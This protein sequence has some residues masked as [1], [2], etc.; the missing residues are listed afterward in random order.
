MGTLDEIKTIMSEVPK[1]GNV[2]RLSNR[3]FMRNT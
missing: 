2:Q 1:K 3:L